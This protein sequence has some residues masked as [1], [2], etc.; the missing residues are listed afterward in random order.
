[1]LGFHFLFFFF[2]FFFFSEKTPETNVLTTIPS[3]E[4]ETIIFIAV[5]ASYG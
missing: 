2:F 5:S 3:G 1:M 4:K